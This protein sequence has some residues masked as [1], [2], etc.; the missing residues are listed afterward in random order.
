[1]ITQQGAL[2]T[3]AL[4]V[5]DVYLQI[6]PPQYLI[7]G[8]PSNVL[9]LVGTATWG[10]VNNP[11][12]IG[13]LAQY[14]ALFGPYQNRNFDMGTHAAIALQ[15]GAA[16]IQCVRVTDGTD[17]AAAGT[18]PAAA[19]PAAGSIAFT[20]Q[21]TAN[22]TITLN[23]TVITFVA[24][25]AT[26]SQVN[27]GGSLTATLAALLTFLQGSA[28]TQL[29]KFSYA[30]NGNTLGLTAVT[31][32]T[33]GNAL[34]IAT[35]VTGATPSGATLSGGLAASTNLTLTSKWTGSFGNG[36]KVTIGAGSAANSQ[37]VKIA[38]PGIVPEIFD[39]ITGTGNALWVAV[40]AAINNGNAT[41]GPSQIITATAGAGTTTPATA[42][43]SLANGTDGAS[44]INGTVMQGTDSSPRTGMYALRGMGVAIAIL[45]DLTDTT[46]W[47]N[48]NAF[49]L[50]EGIYMVTAFAAGSYD[51]TTIAALKATAG[52]DSYAMKIMSGDWLYWNDTANGA[53]QRL[54][55]PA[56]L[57]GGRLANMD[58]S[59]SSLNKQLRGVVGSQKSLT[60]LPYT[61]ADLQTL[62]L[63]GIDVICNPVPG[64]KYFG[65]RN[66]RNASSNAVIHGDNYTRMTNYLASTLN[67]ALGI[68]VGK[69]QSQT[70][71]RQAKTTIDSFFSNLQQQGLIGTPDG[72][73]D[74]W[75]CVLDN[76][77]NPPSR[78][79]LGYMQADIQVQYLSIIEFFLAN[80]EAGQSVQIT[81]KAPNFAV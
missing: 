78:V 8:V 2:N 6:V 16:A 56:A 30:V 3:T 32:G 59:Q 26:G 79:A 41:R 63:A 44:T 75:V 38:A 58:P 42:T 7:N 35:N 20:G 23:G 50:S 48:Q 70:V 39:N 36:I 1:M 55:S 29:V 5:A 60:G 51:P 62:A 71:R 9:G 46:T 31:A 34:T 69:L 80:L 25:G 37:Q 66:G 64:G 4:T 72:A 22:Q 47:A 74:A 49:G 67:T 61:S 27:I 28:D 65:C 45:C 18:V 54:V 33:S 13:S 15:Q 76:T 21:P 10:P 81:R 12:V 68:Y 43:Y 19:V 73:S 52:I 17:V 40:A 53:P 57:V 77:N 11:S 24:S 14:Q